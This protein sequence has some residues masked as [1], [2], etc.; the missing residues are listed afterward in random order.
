M[1]RFEPQIAHRGGHE[2]ENNRDIWILPQRILHAPADGK[3]ITL[4]I[5][6]DERDLPRPGLEKTVNAGQR[7]TDFFRPWMCRTKLFRGNP[8]IRMVAIID[9][10]VDGPVPGPDSQLDRDDFGFELRL[11]RGLLQNSEV[12]R[13]RFECIDRAAGLCGS[14]Q[15]GCCVANVCT[16]IQDISPINQS[17]I[18]M[19]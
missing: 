16:D 5:N 6:F 15:N 1:A 2:F 9:P 12:E 14:R 11:L 4:N 3:F 13:L 10:Q 17:G 18:G 19:Q 7:D 8:V